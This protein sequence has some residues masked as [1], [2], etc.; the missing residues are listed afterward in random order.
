MPCADQRLWRGWLSK[1]APGH[2]KVLGSALE[3]SVQL[4]RCGKLWYY[5]VH[6]TFGAQG[7][8]AHTAVWYDSLRTSTGCGG[9]AHA[10]VVMDAAHDSKSLLDR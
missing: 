2:V 7:V 6:L 3:V 10:C 9:S 8:A 5:T 1:I 4:R